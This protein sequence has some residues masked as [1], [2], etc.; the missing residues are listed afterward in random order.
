MS[1]ASLPWYDL[2]EV[3][4]ATDALWAA[5]ARHL[6]A[7]GIEGVPAALDRE[8]P[9]QAQWRSGRLLLSQACGYDVRIAYAGH[10]QLVATPCYHVEGAGDCMYSSLVVV[11]EDSP[12]RE[13]ADL[14]GARCLINTGTSHSGMN[15][16]RA[17]VAPLHEEGRFFA[18]VQVSGAHRTS[19]ARISRGRADV[20]AIDCVTYALVERHTPSL[21]AGTRVLCRTASVPAPPV[22][23]RAGIP[24]ADLAHLRAALA[25]TLADPELE[26]ARE[27][28]FLAGTA[29]RP[30]EAYDHIVEL[31]RLADQYGYFEIHSRLG[32]EP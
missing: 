21:L 9:Y 20:A 30:L 6:R 7:Q 2:E 32:D 29:V 27:E 14:R 31:E 25:A 26:W 5:L 28:T 10:L 24:A 18:S 11:R 16:L 1:I 17:M 3:R 15:I 12:Y 23:T 13:L 4:P 19:L 8:T 22:V